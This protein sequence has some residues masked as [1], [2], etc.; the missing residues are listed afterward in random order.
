MSNHLAA[1]MAHQQI[2]DRLRAADQRR[3]AREARSGDT[4][5]YEPAP[6]VVVRRRPR[7]L[8]RVLPV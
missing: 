5:D 3:L 2:T 1:S 6:P 4:L 8:F 7:G